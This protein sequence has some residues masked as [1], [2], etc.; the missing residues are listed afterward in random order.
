[1]PHDRKNENIKQK[2]YCN[3]FNKDLEKIF[4]K[5]E[6]IPEVKICPAG[7]ARLAEHAAQSLNSDISETER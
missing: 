7:S 6:I 5:K 2:E 4:K 1:M 3:K